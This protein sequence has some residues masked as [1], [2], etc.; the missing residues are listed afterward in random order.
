MKPTV[1]LYNLRNPKG[2]Q[3]ELLCLGQNIAC[4]HVE[5]AQYGLRI[6][7][8][9]QIDGFDATPKNIV[10]EPFTDEM[11]LFKGFDQNM[12]G[13]FLARYRE[14]GIEVVPLKAGLTPTNIQWSSTELIAEL[15]QERDEFLK[16][17]QG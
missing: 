13:D 7:H 5:P 17:K 15:R 12:L 4:Q 9:A 3:I 16:Q 6:G 1:Y 2:R 8:I 11:I 14:A 10:T